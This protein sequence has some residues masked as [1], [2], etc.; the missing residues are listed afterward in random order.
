M[1]EEAFEIVTYNQER[2]RN[3]GAN[4][5]V[6][7]SKNKDII[8]IIESKL[9]VLS[10]KHMAVV[11]QVDLTFFADDVY[12]RY[13]TD[14]IVEITTDNNDRFV[15]NESSNLFLNNKTGRYFNISCDDD[16][17]EIKVTDN[18]NDIY[19]DT[20]DNWIQMTLHDR[21]MYYMNV[22]DG[23]HFLNVLTFQRTED[24]KETQYHE[25]RITDLHAKRDDVEDYKFNK[26]KCVEPTKVHVPFGIEFIIAEAKD[27]L[28]EEE[29]S[30]EEEYVDEEYAEE[31]DFTEVESDKDESDVDHV[32]PIVP[33]PSIDGVGDN[34]Y[35]GNTNINIRG[36]HFDPYQLH[37]NQKL[38]RL[39][40]ER[41]STLVHFELVT[42]SKLLVIKQV[43]AFST[44]YVITI[45]NIVD[46]IQR[47]CI[48]NMSDGKVIRYIELPFN[49]KIIIDHD[50][51]IASEQHS[52]TIHLYHIP[53]GKLH[54]LSTNINSQSESI[55]G[56]SGDRNFLLWHSDNK[57]TRFGISLFNYEP[58]I[59][60]FL[61][62]SIEDKN[63]ALD[64]SS[65]IGFVKSK[66]YD[67][68]LLNEIFAFIRRD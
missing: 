5:F 59:A 67:R 52:S 50:I 30:D 46:N 13:L 58:K 28:D 65:V 68:H 64:K 47:C 51:I 31:E 22:V 48:K 15:Y 39:I 29:Y 60:Q 2:L 44:D 49:V 16:A 43:H 35:L 66:L 3:N 8:Y 20:V 24:H 53:S 63:T 36:Y 38:Q 19:S 1:S 21:S 41:G 23:K 18:Q 10:V 27:Y 11:N 17:T 7:F 26:N 45:I 34:V 40:V 62:G 14:D 61:M 55:I 4:S 6:L 33:H 25:P 32:T 56:I 42:L 57:I 54:S 9:E 37:I 12:L